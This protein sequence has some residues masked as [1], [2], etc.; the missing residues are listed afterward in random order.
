M[1]DVT[2]TWTNSQMVGDE[3]LELWLKK[4]AAAWAQEAAVLAFGSSQN[5][6]FEGLA[7]DVNHVFQAR[8]RR[9]GEYRPEYTSANPEDWPV[10]SRLEFVPSATVTA[11]GAP[12]LDDTSWERVSS[13][14]TKVTATAT[15]NPSHESLDLQLLRG[16]TVV[17]T[18]AGPHTGPVVLTDVD[19][20][21]ET[22]QPY[23]VRHIDTGV[24]GSNSNT[25]DQYIGPAP[26][27]SNVEFSQ[28]FDCGYTVN[29]VNQ[30]GGAVTK[31][32]HDWPGGGFTEVATVGA[33]VT[34]QQVS[35]GTGAFLCPDDDP[36]LVAVRL[37]HGV[38]AFGVTD[39]T[40]P[41][42]RSDLTLKSECEC[43]EF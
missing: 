29:W 15:A 16:N 2:I 17:D 26:P 1:R 22:T 28:V 6:T 33:G 36:V 11:P 23:R 5:R 40:L 24:P 43:T 34:Q 18:V 14:S 3:V 8:A 10:G 12:T 42:Q 20:P 21:L 30:I 39:F 4:G 7:A 9:G 13:S 19:P 38:E 35:V 27:P 31:I 32:E 37:R 25:I 41:V